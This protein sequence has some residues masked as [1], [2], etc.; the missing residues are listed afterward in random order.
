MIHRR[1]FPLLC[2]LTAVGWASSQAVH[3]QPVSSG[4]DCSAYPYASPFPSVPASYKH[5]YQ[6]IDQTFLDME[7]EVGP[8]TP[9]EYAILDA[10]LD[11]AKQRLKPIPA[12]LSPA[13]YDA[14]AVAALKTMDCILVRHG[15]VYPGVGLVPLLSD[16]L[17]STNFTGVYLER[18]TG[19]SVAD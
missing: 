15:F 18:L 8:V 17:G 9:A 4:R 12:G 7:N 14:F 11:E 6:G 2:L 3:A 16:G 10:L 5:R 1:L 13:D 19:S